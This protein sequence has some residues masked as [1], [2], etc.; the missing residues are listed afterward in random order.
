[1]TEP[2]TYRTATP[3]DADE[4]ARL[5]TAANSARHAEL[6]LPVGAPDAAAVVRGRLELPGTFAVLGER[7]GAAVAVAIA[8]PALAD[9]GASA[10]LVPG[11]VHVSTVAV[12]PDAWGQRLGALVLARLLRTA[13]E[14]G[15]TDAQL[16]T[17]E[18]NRRARALYER[19]GWTA[20]GR[21]KTHDSGEPIRH[22]VLPLPPTS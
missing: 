10:E 2:V 9:D 3:A 4:I 13:S 16:W 8:L 1:M 14:R 19:T 7:A 12:H 22:Y 17:H 15:F 11:L 21:T 6:G 18:T 5:W 20:S